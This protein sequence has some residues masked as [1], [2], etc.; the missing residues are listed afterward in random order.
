MRHAGRI[1]IEQLESE[2]VDTVYCVPGESYLAALDGLYDSNRIRTVVC[3]HE[4]GA[5]MMADAHARMTGKPGVAFVTRGPGATNASIGVH[6]AQQDSVPLVLFVGLPGRDVEDREAFQEFDLR[7]VFGSLAKWA[8]VV[9]DVSR[10]QEYVSRAFHIAASGRPGP[11][12]LGLPEDMIS[13]SLDAAPIRPSRPAESAPTRA[14]MAE[15]AKLLTHAERPLVI[16]GGPGWSAA[17]KAKFEE[18][19]KNLDLPVA[20]AFRCQDYFDN[21]HPCYAGHAGIGIEGKLAEAIAS[22]DVLLVI[23]ARLG[24]MTTSGYTLVN[25][26]EPRQKLVH[27][28]PSA[29][30]LGRVYR[31]E[32]PIC[33]A[34][35]TFVDALAALAVPRNPN[36]ANRTAALHAA[37][38]AFSRPEPTPGALKME[39]VIANLEDMLPDDGIVTCGAGN[40]ATFLHRYFVHKQFRT[41]LAPTCGAMGFSLPAAIAAKL[42]RPDRIVVAL[43]GDGGF[44]MNGQELAT[45]V[46]YG[47]NI[48]VLIAN[49][50]LYGTIRMHQ[51]RNYPGR[52]MATSLVNPDFAA[53][54]RSYG[55]FGEVVTD[56]EQFRGA[57]ARA[58]EA[59]KPALLEL[60]LDPEA[61]TTRQTLSQIRAAAE[62]PK[63]R[64]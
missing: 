48:I 64:V 49:N 63:A 32:L 61:L 4:G 27:V 51:E 42:A 30:E 10:L 21:R 5:A 59:G 41:L 58:R 53:L 24:E 33:S 62:T 40:Y 11:V 13:A 45:A 56:T 37:Y 29:D 12:V 15:L 36:W 60:K 35:G 8:E 39:M 31:A 3:R 44:L 18:I 14:D 28:H 23:G 2:G 47:A 43:E 38:Q 20:C 25:V 57:F 9:N 54:A 52:V 19:A 34:A 17:I 6:I 16:L 22:A 1:L 55:A 7:A 26:P 46:Q 50:G